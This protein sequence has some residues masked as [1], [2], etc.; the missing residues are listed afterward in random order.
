MNSHAEL[1]K[2]VNRVSFS[3]VELPVCATNGKAIEACCANLHLARK[4]LMEGKRKVAR[5]HVEAAERH[6][7][8]ARVC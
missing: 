8:A 4:A 3:I 2:H 6:C 1:W 7:E 5:K